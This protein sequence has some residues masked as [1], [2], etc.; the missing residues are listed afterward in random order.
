VIPFENRSS[1]RP[2]TFGDEA[3]AAVT[4]E[5]TDRLLLDVLPRADVVLQMRTLGLQVP[6]SNA[7]FVRLG[8]ELD[9]A[10]L[11]SGEVR[12]ARV[13]SG[14]QG[15]YGEVVLAVRLFDSVAKV[16][17]NGALV[18]GKG[19]GSPDASDEVLL[20]KALQQAAFE[21]VELMKSRP[22]I[23]AMVL[24]TR[25]DVAY[26][27]VGA[28][29]GL[30]PG[31]HLAAVRGGE[32]IGLA[33]VDQAD[34]L[35]AYVRVIQGPPLRTGDQLRAVY[36]LP[37]DA[38]PERVATSE[39][40]KKSFESLVILGA[41]VFGF[42]Q[43]ASRSRRLEEGNV[44][45]PSFRA[46]SLA[47]GAELA[48]SG[49]APSIYPTRS[50]QP[51]PAALI[52]WEGYQGTESS[53]LIAYDI[54]RSFGA[55][56]IVDIVVFEFTGVANR[57]IDANTFPSFVT[58]Y[59]EIDD[60]TGGIAEYTVET[61]LWDP[62]DWDPETAT[63]ANPW[64]DF[65]ES[66]ADQAGIEL[67]ATSIQWSWF[68]S[69]MPGDEVG[70]MF[71]G[72]F[73]QYTLR[74]ILVQ[75][76]R[77]GVWFLRQD[78]EFTT[79]PNQVVAVAPALTSPT[80]WDFV[81][82]DFTGVY[83]IW[84]PI[85]NPVISGSSATF[86]FY[87]PFGADEIV[88]QVSRDPNVRFAPPAVAN[89]SVP[90]ELPDI[91]QREYPTSSVTMDLSTVPGV[92]AFFWWRIGARNSAD[93]RLPRTWPV[94]DPYDSGFT[95]SA[96]SGFLIPTVSRAEL[97]HKQREALSAA[98]AAAARVPRGAAADRVLRAE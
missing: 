22:T 18:V 17:T 52:T 44:A 38:G 3:S 56:D 89:V 62:G 97:M 28:R 65:V 5:L 82:Y 33:E 26:L 64:A 20:D 19:P 41:L 55:L 30:R 25:G 73:Y 46:S 63:F 40:K 13:L 93:T 87:Y 96:R 59:L 36:T 34:A 27:N 54:R 12:G 51:H 6:L 1:F 72:V 14:P 8:S 48:Y 57:L 69:M 67:T 61:E 86:Y 92:G 85:D 42:G 9:V 4:A 11:V 50:W 31:M 68:P 53:R 81:G 83:E 77:D 10:L 91:S 71:P 74:P 37:A 98:R 75:R 29:G 49:Y 2:E 45:A 70:G 66:F 90:P 24:W 15:R 94:G 84:N 79:S 39:K 32:R 76:N 7:E 23:T 43:Y 80:H 35:G 21:A 88:L 58:V 60:A 16:D 47:N 78:T 95:W